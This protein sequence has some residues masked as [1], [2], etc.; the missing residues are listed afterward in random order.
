MSKSNHVH[1]TFP[2]LAR[3]YDRA[4][5]SVSVVSPQSITRFSND[6]TRES[7]DTDDDWWENHRR[8]IKEWDFEQHI[9]TLNLQTWCDLGSSSMPQLY[10]MLFQRTRTFMAAVEDLVTVTIKQDP[11]KWGE[12]ASLIVEYSIKVLTSKELGF[13]G[14]LHSQRESVYWILDEAL[15]RIC[16]DQWD[17]ERTNKVWDKVTEPIRL[18]LLS[19]KGKLQDWVKLDLQEH[20]E[21]W[22]MKFSDDYIFIKRYFERTLHFL[23]QSIRLYEIWRTVGMSRIGQLPKELVEVIVEDILDF[24]DLPAGELRQRH[25]LKGKGKDYYSW[26]H[27]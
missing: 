2:S 8:Q 1:R 13:H 7:T 10:Y 12:A 21:Y 22:K 19:A 3:G 25:L 24:E 27:D 26:R 16:L 5:H 17:N 4:T 14:F 9:K 6:P 18:A 15:L 11:L 23:D 20:M